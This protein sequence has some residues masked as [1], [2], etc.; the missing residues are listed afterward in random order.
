MRKIIAGAIAFLLPLLLPVI[1]TA[2]PGREVRIEEGVYTSISPAELEGMLRAKD[3]FLVNVH[4]PYAGEIPRTDAF[5][6]YQDT[7][8]RI[9]EYPRDRT[10]RIVVYCL[11]NRM[12]G[13]A[14]RDLLRSGFTNVSMLDGGMNSWREA[15]FPLINRDRPSPVPYPSAAR[16]PAPAVPETCGCSVE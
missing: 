12:S 4:V 7:S 15:G 11:G 5:I 13:I 6:S 1:A 2:D 9:G 16:E 10:A 8:A 14:V 3:F